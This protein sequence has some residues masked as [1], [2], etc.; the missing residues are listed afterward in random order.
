[1][2]VQGGLKDSSDVVVGDRL[3]L[4]DGG[5]S[6]V[7]S[8]TTIHDVGLYNPQTLQGDIV[9]N[10]IKASTYTKAVKPDLA[11]SLLSP[12]R[13]AYAVFGYSSRAAE[14]GLPAVIVGVLP[15]GSSYI[16]HH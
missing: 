16:S 9:V 6:A 4:G 12:L 5:L 2:Y 10:G 14:Y 11:H 7:V 3:V 15:Q 1:L 8:V 13:L